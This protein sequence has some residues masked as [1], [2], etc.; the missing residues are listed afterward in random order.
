[1]QK[2]TTSTYQTAVT[3]QHRIAMMWLWGQFAKFYAG[4]AKR[5]LGVIDGDAF[6]IWTDTLKRFSHENIKAGL[7]ATVL[8]KDTWPPDLQEFIQLCVSNR[9]QACHKK[10]K[11]IAGIKS[12][13]EHAAPYLRELKGMTGNA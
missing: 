11:L 7:R 2:S 8:R 1:M 12:T 5:N 9:P 13:K 3:D 6:L 10:P 4:K